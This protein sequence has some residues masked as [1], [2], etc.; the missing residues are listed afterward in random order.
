LAD[1]DLEAWFATEQ[2]EMHLAAFEL[3]HTLAGVT[4]DVTFKAAL[5]ELETVQRGITDGLVA[6]RRTN[7]IAQSTHPVYLLSVKDGMVQVVYGT[8]WCFHADVAN[9]ALVALMGDKYRA[10][11]AIKEPSVMRLSGTVQV[12]TNHFGGVVKVRAKE[13]DAIITELGAD[14]NE[15]DLVA[16]LAAPGALI[17]AV[18]MLPVAPKLAVF[19]MRGMT[20]L[21]AAKLVQRIVAQ[22][23][24]AEEAKVE[25]LVNFCRVACTGV[26]G[27]SAATANWMVVDPNDSL[28]LYE[29]CDGQKRPFFQRVSAPPPFH[30]VVAQREERVQES[31]AA[32]E[33]LKRSAEAMEKMASLHE[34]VKKGTKW[35]KAD[36]KRYVKIANCEAYGGPDVSIMSE[37]YQGLEAEKNQS[38]TARHYIEENLVI[39]IDEDSLEGM[40]YTTV[41]GTSVIDAIRRLNPNGSDGVFTWELRDKGISVFNLAPVPTALLPAA[42]ALRDTCMQHEE[43]EGQKQQDLARASKV[44]TLVEKW[45]LTRERAYVWIW[46]LHRYTKILF[47]SGWILHD[48]LR[49]LLK[50]MRKE[51]V[52]HGMS[53]RDI[54]ALIWGIHVGV[55]M[56]LGTTTSM[57]WIQ[58]VIDDF[59]TGRVPDWTKFRP[60]VQAELPADERASLPSQAHQGGG[61][62]GGGGA[63]GGGGRVKRNFEAMTGVSYGSAIAPDFTKAW[64]EDV[65][66]VHTAYQGLAHGRIFFPSQD[67]LETLLGSEF[68]ALVP[69]NGP[70]AC[71]SFFLLGKCRT[72]CTRCH[73][74]TG[75]PSQQV[76]AGIRERMK[77]HCKAL[78]QAKNG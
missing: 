25:A 73:K 42:N 47:G 17:L 61:G 44:T 31:T 78:V 52:W 63:T 26:G 51:E 59:D 28:L 54:G 75:T 9:Q 35:A 11:R 23:P 3:G 72:D 38:G 1:I 12:R 56:A 8:N 19:S 7:E 53:Q 46:I 36:L 60:C 50:V 6:F 22:V 10:G 33:M 77:V 21:D 48:K 24:V 43:A 70:T 40:N 57:A 15:E 55:R 68:I 18:R 41:Y 74:T 16:A 49:A 62:G 64:A 67:K 29:W 27:I 66:A 69:P 76:V 5:A 39:T 13:L 58:R 2:E 20:V 37:F 4:R 45:P 34:G 14:D 65:K 32:E 30:P 71:G